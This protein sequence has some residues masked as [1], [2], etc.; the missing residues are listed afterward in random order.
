MED[1]K[2]AIVTQC[3][4]C[5]EFLDIANLNTVCG[6]C[7]DKYCDSDGVVKE[8]IW[9]K[10][11]LEEQR[12]EILEEYDYRTV[13]NFCDDYI[14]SN[15]NRTLRFIEYKGVKGLKEELKGVLD[16]FISSYIDMKEG[17]NSCQT[18][19]NGKWLVW[20]SGAYDGYHPL[21]EVRFAFEV[22]YEQDASQ[23]FLK[24]YKG[25]NK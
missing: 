3:E 8:I 12:D 1:Q 6:L 20:M 25:E 5:G 23:R 7:S 21:M 19:V 18:Y 24:K 15:P 14:T 17:K 4:I 11:Q 9:T 22:G 13:L 10:E 2:K 16:G